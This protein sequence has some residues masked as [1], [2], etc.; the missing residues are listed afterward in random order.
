MAYDESKQT[1]LGQLKALATRAH[2]EAVALDTKLTALEEGTIQSVKVNGT[3]LTPN[4]NAVDVVITVEKKNTANDDFAASYVL[5]ANGVAVGDAINIPKDYLVKSA[6]LETVTAADKA[7]ASGDD[8]AGWAYGNNEYTVGD[9]YLDFVV[10]TK[11]DGDGTAEADSHIRINVKD[12]VDLYTN[13]NGLNLV[14]GEFSIKLDNTG[15]DGLTVGANGL[16]LGAATPD[17]YSGGT[18]TADGVAGAMSSADKYKL[19]GISDE[20]KKVTDTTEGDGS[21]EID[22]VTKHIV[23]IATDAEVEEMLDEVFGTEEEEGGE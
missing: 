4:N 17:T 10:N 5:K 14:N 19:N 8:P 3:A 11:A 9:K 23:Y 13:G 21:I 2:A 18:K 12:L 1:K 15:A 6:T 7:A 16:K 22:G 20:A